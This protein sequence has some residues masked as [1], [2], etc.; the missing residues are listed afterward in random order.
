MSVVLNVKYI[1][2][3]CL[4]PTQF[5][6]RLHLNLISSLELNAFQIG[7]EGR[8]GEIMKIMYELEIQLH[9]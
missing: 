8:E 2:Y 1:F 6:E 9:I 4:K 7:L 5:F 3:L